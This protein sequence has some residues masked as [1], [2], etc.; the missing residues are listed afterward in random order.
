[1]YELTFKK[2][3]WIVKQYLNG[4]STSKIALA[5]KRAFGTDMIIS[6]IVGE[7]IPHA[8]VWVFPDNSADS[9]KN[10]FVFASERGGRLT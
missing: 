10:D 5:Q 2:R 7:E 1:M 4:V 3:I 6:R 9:D 8:H